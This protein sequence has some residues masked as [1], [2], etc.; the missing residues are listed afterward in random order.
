MFRNN[1]VSVLMPA[2]NEEK[3][4]AKVISGIPKQIVDEII[5]IDNGSTD[6]T[7]ALAVQNGARLVREQR[8]GYGVCCLRGIEA[9]SDTDII[10][11]LDSDYSDYPQQINRLIEPIAA[12]E[13]DFVI[14]SRVLGRLEDGALTPQQYWG[15]KL[16]VFMIHRLFG[17][18]FTD[19]GPF[20]AIR[21]ESLK[22]LDMQDKDFG[23][24]AEMQIKAVKS[25]L[26]IKEVPVDYRKRIGDSKI[27]GTISGTIK[28]GTKIIFTIFKYFLE[29]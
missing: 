13:A 22:K 23:W 15:N 28:A 18:R 9:I 16:A 24:N 27:S 10:V 8:R 20:R 2:Y 19:M 29:R 4:I 25:G 3:S 1:K 5:V 14:G 21:Y 7:A 6:N 17:Y 26:K 12:G 11:I